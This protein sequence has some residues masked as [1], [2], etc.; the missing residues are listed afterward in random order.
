MKNCSRCSGCR[1]NFY[2][3]NNSLG[4]TK[5]WSLDTAKV[6]WRIAIGYW[7]EPPYLNKKKVQVPDCW[8]G[9]GSNRTQYVPASAITKKGFW[10]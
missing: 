2:N 9:Q 10:K 1:N 6:V 4:V 5:C 7:E 8:H 3:G